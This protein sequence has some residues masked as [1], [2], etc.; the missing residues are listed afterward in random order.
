MKVKG[1][2]ALVTGASSGIGEAL[3]L[4]LSRLGASLILS[5]RNL[6]RLERVADVMVGE[7]LTLPFDATD[8]EGLDEVVERACGWRGRVDTSSITPASGGAV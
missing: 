4:E 5:G 1:S 8:I 3:A 7:T 6:A 2:I